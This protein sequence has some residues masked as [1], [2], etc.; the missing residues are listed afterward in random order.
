MTATFGR[1][2][3]TMSDDEIETA[4]TVFFACVA[5]LVIGLAI[6]ALCLVGTIGCCLFDCI[7]CFCKCCKRGAK[8]ESDSSSTKDGNASDA[9]NNHHV[10]RYSSMFLMVISILVALVMQFYVAKH[11]DDFETTEKAWQAGGCEQGH[12]RYP[13]CLE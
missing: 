10:G 11:F 5:L 7:S 9:A 3:S 4:T 1:Q 8:S 13:K 6:R 12:A 2:L